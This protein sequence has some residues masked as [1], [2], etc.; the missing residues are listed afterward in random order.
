[1]TSTP[2]SKL[3]PSRRVRVD[4]RV[5]SHLLALPLQNHGISTRL[6]RLDYGDVCF[7]GWRKG[8]VVRIGIERKTVED[9]IGSMLSKRLIDRQLPGMAGAYDVRYLIVEGVWRP[10]ESGGIE[11]LRCRGSWCGWRPA[12]TSLT[13][14]QLNR[15]LITMANFGGV[16]VWRS[17]GL[18]ETVAMIAD[19]FAWWQKKKHKAHLGFHTP[20]MYDTNALDPDTTRKRLRRVAEH[21]PHV[22]W[23]RGIDVAKHFDSIEDMVMAH[24]KRWLRIPRFGPKMANDIRDA[25][26]ARIRR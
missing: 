20:P 17:S 10:S 9:L 8:K 26:T 1:M 22:G 18:D 15:F 5:G 3:E 25:I 4:D 19:L 24:R 21:F 11:I 7:E 2:T 14:A 12:R 23:F 16:A 6:R 13:Y